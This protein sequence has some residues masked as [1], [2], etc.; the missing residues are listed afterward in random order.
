M[1]FINV[2]DL[3]EL[4]SLYDAHQSQNHQNNLIP[5][6]PQVDTVPSLSSFVD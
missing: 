3:L 1:P 4:Q 6:T 2:K 5:K